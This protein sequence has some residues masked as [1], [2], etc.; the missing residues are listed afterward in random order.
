MAAVRTSWYSDRVEREVGMSRWGEFGHPVLC[1]PTASGDAGEIER[2]H[3]VDALAPLMEAG[4]LKLYSVD[5]VP[6]QVWL[7]EYN[8]PPY[9][10]RMQTAYNEYLVNEVVPAIVSDCGGPDGVGDGIVVTGASVGAYNALAAICRHPLLF[11]KA[12]CMSGT[13]D[14]H[15]FIDG[16]VDGD[17]Y[18]ASPLH[19]I[20]NLPEDH[21]DLAVLR[22]RFVVLA[23][24]SG[25]WERADNSWD[26]AEVLGARG[27]PNRVDDWGPQ[28][29]HDWPTW[30]AML[31][32]Y[33]DDLLP[34]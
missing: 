23:N 29:D 31:P 10:T 30:R 34:G 13:Y 32:L 4:R 5:S 6:G 19:F 27:I 8:R 33:L 14:L 17:W 11:S 1:F 2:F 21:P 22:Q 12:I 16:E 15:R 7:N 25:R 9:A 24:G 20:P 18:H 3:L 28:W 26:V